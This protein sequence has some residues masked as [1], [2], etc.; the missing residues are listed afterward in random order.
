MTSDTEIR[1]WLIRQIADYLSL[2]ADLIDPATPLQTYGLN[3]ILAL[4]LSVDIEDHF[5]LLVDAE[6]AWDLET[7][8]AITA[9]LT[10]ALTP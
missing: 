9:H 7:V 3:S 1:A 10:S 5:G 8:D 2:P 4:T 6:L